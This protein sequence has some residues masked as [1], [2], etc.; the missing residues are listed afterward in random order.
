[1]HVFAWTVRLPTVAFSRSVCCHCRLHGKREKT[2]LLESRSP[3]AIRYVLD[4]CF[5]FVAQHDDAFG[6]KQ[7]SPTI[8]ALRA[9]ATPGSAVQRR[10]HVATVATGS[11]TFL[12]CI[13]Q[14]K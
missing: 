5:R 13:W 14:Q 7:A 1:M 4:L 11:F 10:M 9:P 2:F 8:K 3:S 6:D 12:L